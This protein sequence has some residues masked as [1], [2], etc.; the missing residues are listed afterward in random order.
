MLAR[1]GARIM[2]VRVDLTVMCVGV[3]QSSTPNGKSC[4]RPR[5]C[6]SS[7]IAA[8]ARASASEAPPRARTVRHKPVLGTGTVQNRRITRAI[9]YG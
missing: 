7:Y 8:R 9:T 2:R 3:V 4:L 5:P 6:L 1:I